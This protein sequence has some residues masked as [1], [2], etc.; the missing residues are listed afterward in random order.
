MDN[1]LRK[2]V[3]TISKLL[4]KGSAGI[5]SS[6]GNSTLTECLIKAA[7][8]ARDAVKQWPV[9]PDVSM[10][11]IVLKYIFKMDGKVAYVKT[12]QEAT[13]DVIDAMSFDSVAQA[14]DWAN[15]HGFSSMCVVTNV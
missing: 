1:D 7:D 15:H 9:M 5:R 12:K 8:L 4:D 11:F 6:T 3:E 2:R 10:D 13:S 14:Q